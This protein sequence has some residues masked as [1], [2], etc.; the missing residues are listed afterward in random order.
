MQRLTG[1]EILERL[2]AVR[3]PREQIGR[4]AGLGGRLIG[5][6]SAAPHG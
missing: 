2:A 4:R 5:R 1:A 3:A 6:P